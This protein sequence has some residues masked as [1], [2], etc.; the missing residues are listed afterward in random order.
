LLSAPKIMG[1]RSTL[2][3]NYIHY[4]QPNEHKTGSEPHI[5]NIFSV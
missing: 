5:A 2:I 4:I 3:L 1:V